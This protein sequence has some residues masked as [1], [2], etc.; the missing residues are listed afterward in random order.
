MSEDNVVVATAVQT[1]VVRQDELRT[2]HTKANA[3][4]AIERSGVL[5]VVQAIQSMLDI[6]ADQTD[7]GAVSQD[8]FDQHTHS[9]EA[10]T[11]QPRGW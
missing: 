7:D 4:D 11:D 10:T 1:E 9:F 5:G 8:E 3:F 6:R 2:L